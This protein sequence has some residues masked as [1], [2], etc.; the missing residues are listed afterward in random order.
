MKTLIHG[1][2]LNALALL[3]LVTKDDAVHDS[4]VGKK[5]DAVRG[6]VLDKL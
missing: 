1:D 6:S 3:V 2:R 4:I 5:A